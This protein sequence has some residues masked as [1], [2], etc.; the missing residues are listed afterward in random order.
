[1]LTGGVQTDFPV[2]SNTS[3][4]AQALAQRFISPASVRMSTE[5]TMNY[6]SRTLY[7]V[8]ASVECTRACMY[9]AG[10]ATNPQRFKWSGDRLALPLWAGKRTNFEH[11]DIL[12]SFVNVRKPDMTMVTLQ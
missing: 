2:V 1:M 8:R 3:E 5:I 12:S 9:H 7:T 10:H 11:D 4:F 6:A